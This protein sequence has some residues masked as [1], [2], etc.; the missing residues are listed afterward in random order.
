MILFALPG[1]GSKLVF[2]ADA[3]KS[4]LLDHHRNLIYGGTVSQNAPFGT[5]NEPTEYKTANRQLV[6]QNQYKMNQ[7]S[8]SSCHHAGYNIINYQQDMHRSY[9]D[10]KI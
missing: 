3:K 6:G 8:Q 2:D 10:E 5:F 1:I 4:F 7:G 9:Q